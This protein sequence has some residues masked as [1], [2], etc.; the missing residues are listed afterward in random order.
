MLG[1]SCVRSGGVGAGS[2]GAGGTR[3]ALEGTWVSEVSGEALGAEDRAGQGK[4]RWAEPGARVRP[5]GAFWAR[6]LRGA[7]GA[8]A[9]A[10]PA[11][12][13]VSDRTSVSCHFP[14]AGRA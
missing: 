1:G 12:T 8:L 5:W 2:W 4:G 7:G 10:K 3:K 13:G 6:L 14:G 9:G 11:G